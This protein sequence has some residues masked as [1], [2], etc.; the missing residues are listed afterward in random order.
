MGDKRTLGEKVSDSIASF[1]GSWK[2]IFCFSAFLTTWILFNTYIPS[3]AFDKPPYILL[4]LILSFVASFQAPFILM[5]QNRAAKRQE[6]SYM[7]LLKEIKYLIQKDK[8]DNGMML[9]KL[10]DV[11]DAI[12]SEKE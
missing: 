1:G 11:L 7:T 4:N 10:N 9:E 6:E 8:V 12:E 2:F 3:L 5:S